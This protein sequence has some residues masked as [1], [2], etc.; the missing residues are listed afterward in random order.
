MSNEFETVRV[1]SIREVVEGGTY[2]VY[3]LGTVKVTNVF[4]N[5]DWND[6]CIQVKDAARGRDYTCIVSDLWKEVV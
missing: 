4:F 6:W 2:Y 5:E 1:E 3:E